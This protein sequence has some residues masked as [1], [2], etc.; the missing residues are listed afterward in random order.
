ML[1]TLWHVSIYLHLKQIVS[2][3]CVRAI[4]P[5]SYQ[6]RT[7]LT[8]SSSL[9]ILCDLSSNEGTSCPDRFTLTCRHHPN[10]HQRQLCFYS[11]RSVKVSHGTVPNWWENLFWL[12]CLHE[13]WS[14]TVCVCLCARVRMQSSYSVSLSRLHYTGDSKFKHRFGWHSVQINIIMVYFI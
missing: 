7:T 2:A 9:F 13:P 3:W 14:P 8:F 1:I 4:M 11:S 6:R 5:P 12:T 10:L